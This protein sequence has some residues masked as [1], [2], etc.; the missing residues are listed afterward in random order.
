[1]MPELERQ[2]LVAIA[3]ETQTHCEL[4]VL[5]DG[6]V[7]PR[8][9]SNGILNSVISGDGSALEPGMEVH[10]YAWD[11]IPLASVTPKGSC[12][13]PY[14]QRLG[15]LVRQ[16]SSAGCPRLH[17]ID[18]RIVHSYDEALDHYRELLRKGKEGTIVK[19]PKMIWKDGTSKDQVKLKLEV[20]VDLKIVGV[21]NGT[22]GTKNEGRPGS[23]E[24]E[25]ACG[26]L[27]VDVTVKNEAMRDA[28]ERDPHSYL[29]RILAVRANSVMNP[30]DSSPVHS[31]FLP[32][33]VEAGY[34]TDKAE[35]DDLARIKAQFEAA[36]EAV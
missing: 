6:V 36:V 35:A 18:T 27:R 32:R 14:A 19:N 12:S 17:V 33:M 25:S 11:Q 7:L 8:E 22:P 2:A 3:D 26:A 4:L 24:C 31:L 15:G 5:K 20:D 28:I 16:I 13:T 9:Q 30:S 1:V 29:G 10:F 34:R 21:I 23:L